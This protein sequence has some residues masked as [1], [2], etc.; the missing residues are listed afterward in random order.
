MAVLA[1]FGTTSFDDAPDVL[2]E[3]QHALQRDVPDPA[4]LAMHGHAVSL[5]SRRSEVRLRIA[6]HR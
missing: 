2:L 1:E 4:K 3:S 5:Y 6:S